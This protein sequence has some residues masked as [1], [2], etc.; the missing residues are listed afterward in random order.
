MLKKFTPMEYR[1]R[2]KLA[3]EIAGIDN[4]LRLNEAI[5]AKDGYK[6]AP[7][8]VAGKA[9][10]FGEFDLIALYLFRFLSTLGYSQSLA[11]TYACNVLNM[12]KAEY[13]ELP[14]RFDCPLNPFPD[15][16]VAV[17]KD[18]PTTFQ[19]N[20]GGTEFLAHTA[21]SFNI[22]ELRREIQARMEH[23]A[24]RESNTFGEE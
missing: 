13:H 23:V 18:A 3:C 20:V 21:L 11:S 8:T 12:L 15:E 14:E 2:T 4:P 1:F 19:H 5:A 10:E 7:P 24:K 6:C 17:G 16:I 22:P 9:R